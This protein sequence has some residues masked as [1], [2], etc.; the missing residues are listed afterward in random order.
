M[1]GIEHAPTRL[2][3]IGVLVPE[4]EPIVGP[5]RAQYDPSAAQGVGAHL[6][7]LAPFLAP[8]LLTEERIGELKAF[9]AQQPMPPLTFAGVCGFRN[10]I[11]L[12]PEPQ[13]TVSHIIRRLAAFYPETPPYGGTIPLDKIVPH[14]S[15]AFSDDPEELQAISDAFCNVAASRLP[16]VV[17][18]REALLISQDEDLAYRTRAVLRFKT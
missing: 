8:D 3:A 17:H 18:V 5:W 15:V 2:S 6:T 9:F 16:I 14:V 13:D 11:Y 12:P 1:T 4:L 7:L 10:A